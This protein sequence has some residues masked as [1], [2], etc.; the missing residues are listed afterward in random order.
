LADSSIDKTD[1]GENIQV[2]RKPD[3]VRF[4]VDNRLWRFRGLLKNMSYET[5]KVN[6]M[7]KKGNKFFLDTLNLCQ[8]RQRGH[9]IKQAAVELEENEEILIKI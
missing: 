1:L 2:E 4:P 3:E 6:A 8:T 7:V 9:F 5:L